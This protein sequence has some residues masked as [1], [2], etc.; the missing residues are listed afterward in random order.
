MICEIALVLALDVSGSISEPNYRLQ[1]DATAAVLRDQ[2][3][4]RAIDSNYPAAISVIMW[5]DTVRLIIPWR[6]ITGREDSEILARDLERIERPMSGGK[7]MYS[8][9]NY[10]INLFNTV[11]CTPERSVIDVS[12]DGYDDENMIDSARDKA[13]KANITINGLP[14]V[15]DEAPLLEDFF[16]ERVI[17]PDGFVVRSETW[18]AYTRAIRNKIIR[19]IA[20]TAD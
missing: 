9:V 15:T 1:R 17:T 14:I 19:E 16:I 12:S 7:F 11:P 5:S 6:I 3:M 8:A 2:T 4:T 13:A 10:S 20:K 18:P